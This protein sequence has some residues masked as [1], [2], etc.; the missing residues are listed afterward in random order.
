M[1]ILTILFLM[2]IPFLGF[3]S[4]YL[5]SFWFF[6]KESVIVPSIL[7]KSLH[8]SVFL[9]SKQNL[10]LRILKEHEDSILPDGTVIDQIP[11]PYQKT[12]ANQDV[13]VTVAKKERAILVGDFSEKQHDDV[14]D[15]LKK[16]EILSKVF[17]IE[18]QFI[19]GVCIAH[20]PV[21]GET[22]EQKQM[23]LYFSKGNDLTTCLMPDFKND[24]PNE[25]KEFLNKFSIKTEIF[26]KEYVDIQSHDCKNCKVI[27]QRP[28]AGCIMNIQQIQAVQLQVELQRD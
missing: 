18:H 4:G 1:K 20:C 10:G 25:A 14:L 5:L 26:H 2:T 24:N 19:K 3:L 22:L 12:K 7:G 17:F 11:K 21:A 28:A 8:E 27:N 13:F 23:T 9:L 16:R 15:F 6:Q